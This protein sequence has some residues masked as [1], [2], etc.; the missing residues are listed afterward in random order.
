M[1]A[2]LQTRWFVAWALVLGLVLGGCPEDADDDDDVV[3]P[4]DDLQIE[5]LGTMTVT[6]I[7]EEYLDL[8][9][10]ADAVSSSLVMEGG[11]DY[12]LTL[13]SVQ[14]PD[15]VTI[16][17]FDDPYGY[18]IRC[19]PTDDVHTF[20]HPTS[21][22]EALR[23]GTYKVEPYTD[24]DSDYGLSVTAA[25]TAIHKIGAVSGDANLALTFHF[26]GVPGLDAE[27][28]DEHE[29]FQI[30]VDEID[31]ILA[32]A[33]I[34]ISDI[35]YVDVTERVDELTIVEGDAGPSSELGQLLAM[36][37]NGTERRLHI[38]FV[39]GIESGEGFEVVGQ[40]GSAPGPAL[41]Q[42][43]SHS[44][45]AMSTIDLDGAPTL[46]G[47]ATAHEIGHYLGLFHTTEKDGFGWD[48]LDDTPYCDPEM[49]TNG[50][51]VLSAEECAAL[52]ANNVMFWS[53]PEGSD[54]MTSD[55]QWVIQRGPLPY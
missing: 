2:L 47:M 14:D 4:M 1:S 19:F 35:G 54:E 49:D 42:G 44:G 26:V 55:Q 13:Y 6:D 9:V 39:Q 5:D 36:S 34:L 7:G 17:S 3:I 43:T 22:K 40:A 25:L 31:A 53:P 28:A 50:D 15:L 37:G 33:G 46:L 32:G 29:N 27:T 30:A 10:P 11:G 12:L 48:P 24:A 51:S 20:Q 18:N 8:V 21:P 41:V 23:E 16:Y 45:I 38:F 52:D